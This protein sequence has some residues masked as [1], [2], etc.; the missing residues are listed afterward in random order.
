MKEKIPEHVQLATLYL[1]VIFLFFTVNRSTQNKKK[2]AVS[3]SCTV[4]E[5]PI[6]F[7]KNKTYSINKKLVHFPVELNLPRLQ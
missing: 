5:K 4:Y 2:T 1:V 7:L 3:L 6:F